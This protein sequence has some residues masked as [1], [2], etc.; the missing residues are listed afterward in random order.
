MLFSFTAD[1]SSG[2]EVGSSIYCTSGSSDSMSAVGY[3]MPGSGVGN[4][5]SV[6]S[7]QSGKVVGKYRDS[8][9]MWTGNASRPCCKD[10]GSVLCSGML[11]FHYELHTHCSQCE[12]CKDWFETL[13]DSNVDMVGVIRADSNRVGRIAFD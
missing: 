1:S 5:N 2:V 10:I 6:E 3:T 11:D 4:T 8:M 12:N 13:T 9:D 7:E